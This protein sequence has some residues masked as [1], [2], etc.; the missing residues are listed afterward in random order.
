M[1]WVVLCV[2]FVSTLSAAIFEQ[3]RVFQ[4]QGCEAFLNGQYE[5]AIEFFDRAIVLHPDD[6]YLY[7]MRNFCCED[8]IDSGLIETQELKEILFNYG[9]NDACLTPFQY[10]VGMGDLD[11]VA[12]MIKHGADLNGKQRVCYPQSVSGLIGHIAWPTPL[13]QAVLS[14]QI[15]VAR[16]LL[17]QG[18]NTNLRDGQE[19]LTPLMLAQKMGRSRMTN[20]LKEYRS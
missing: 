4:K 3:G 19:G 5:E 11:A 14:N 10:A 20:L 15:E 16:F 2:F 18:A 8:K 1:K 12:L 6:V 13:H 9:N 17:D 7:S